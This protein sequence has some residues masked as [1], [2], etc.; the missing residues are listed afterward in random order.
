MYTQL[1]KEALLKIEDGDTQ[2]IKEFAYF[3][4]LQ[5]DIAVDHIDKFECEYRD[6]T[7][8]W[9]YTGPYF[10]YSMINRG[11]RLMDVDII[12]KIGFFIR[13]L[14]NHLETLSRENQRTEKNATCFQVFRVQSLLLSSFEK[15]KTTEGRLMSF[16]NFLSTSMDRQISCMYAQSA[17]TSHDLNTVGILF[18]ITTDPTLCT[19]SS[20]PFAVV[21]RVGYYEG[22]ER[23]ILFSTH[24]IFH[25]AQINH[26]KDDH[27]D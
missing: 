15:M 21:K 24:T 13:H 27:N 25:I 6:H 20:I 16:N 5:K 17:A 19:K 26:I 4:R 12:L 1:F 11:L 10:I 2:S 22:G 8:I 23:E 18:V 3:C 7:P 14:H 9:W